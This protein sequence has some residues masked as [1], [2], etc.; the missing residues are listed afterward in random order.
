M[1]V[2]N[3][4]ITVTMT[5]IQNIICNCELVVTIVKIQ[6]GLSCSKKATTINSA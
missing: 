4:S 3:Y 2:I 6:I 5:F 1:N